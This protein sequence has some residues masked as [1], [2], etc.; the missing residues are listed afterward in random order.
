[1]CACMCVYVIRTCKHSPDAHN[2]QDWVELKLGAR[3][4][5]RSPLW[6]AGT[7]F[8]EPSSVSQ[9]PLQLNS[10]TPL[11]DADGLTTRLNAHPCGEEFKNYKFFSIQAVLVGRAKLWCARSVHR[12]D[13]EMPWVCPVLWCVAEVGRCR[14]CCSAGGEAHL[15]PLCRCWSLVSCAGPDSR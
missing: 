12:G 2:R 6:V 4:S 9:G 1:M 10:G 7:Q 11:W 5:S 15:E 13:V 3:N 8:L 14:P